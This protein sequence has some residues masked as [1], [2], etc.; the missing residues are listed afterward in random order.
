MPTVELHAEA[1]SVLG[2]HVRRLRRE[3]VIPAN[4][5]GHGP[6]RAIQAPARVLER[7]LQEGGRTSIV[8][9]ALD[10]DVP[11]TA[12]VK[13]VQ[14]D[15]RSGRL[16][17]VDFQAVA[18]NEE[19][20]ASVPVHFV[21]EAPAAKIYGAVLLRPVAELEVEALAGDLPQAIEV[22]LSSL[23]ELH[24]AIHAGEVQTPPGVRIITPAEEVIAVVLPSAVAKEEMAEAAEAAEAAPEA[25]VEQA[26]AKEG[27]D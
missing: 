21:G 7:L 27:G 3:G 1:R 13:S 24:D 20:T 26:P 15:P 11:Q 25:P 17:H 22:D 5:Y 12:L 16:L 18:L 14:R 9:I 19:V 6:S 2:K 10:G 23:V 4:V 8:S